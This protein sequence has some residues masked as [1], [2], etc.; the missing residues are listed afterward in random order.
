M[1]CQCQI[2]SIILKKL[3][4]GNGSVLPDPHDISDDKWMSD[5][6]LLPEIAF[7]DISFYLIVLDSMNTH[8]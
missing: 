5:V 6:T 2:R 4:L 7:A 8:I 3:T 1:A